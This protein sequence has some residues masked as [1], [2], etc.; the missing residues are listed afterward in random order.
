MF[1]LS[2]HRK[3]RDQRE[4]SKM[5]ALVYK[6]NGPYAFEEKPV[7]QIVDPTDAIIQ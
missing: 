2:H 3:Y 4:A 7:P 6:G 1:A 5:K